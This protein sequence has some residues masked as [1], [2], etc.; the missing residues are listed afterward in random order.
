MRAGGG[1]PASLGAVP[2]S[3]PTLVL[4]P[5]FFPVLLCPPGLQCLPV[6]LRLGLGRG[7]GGHTGGAE[8]GT[9]PARE[10]FS[11]PVVTVW[12]LF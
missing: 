8:W 6:G 2:S 5:G 3:G 7:E 1:A 4:P 12:C 11:G 9:A 10:C